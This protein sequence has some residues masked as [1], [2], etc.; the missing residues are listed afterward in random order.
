[1]PS[2]LV[3]PGGHWHLYEKLPSTQTSS[4][5]QL[6]S[7]S[8]HRLAYPSASKRKKNSLWSHLTDKIHFSDNKF[9]LCTTAGMPVLLSVSVK[10]CLFVWVWKYVC[11]CVCENMFVSVSVKICLS[12]WVWKYVCQFEC[13]NMFV[14]LSVKIC[15]SGW[16]WK[17]FFQCEWE[18]RFVSSSVKIGLS[19]GSTTG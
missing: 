6:C 11:Q 3:N 8:S 9:S 12:V 17:Y 16:A 13:E 1:M 4:A 7:F 10:I 5:A 14:S 15:L 2:C 18:I 19:A